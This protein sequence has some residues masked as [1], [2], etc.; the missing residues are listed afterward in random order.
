M[1]KFFGETYLYRDLYNVFIGIFEM[2]FGYKTYSLFLSTIK[3]IMYVG[4]SLFIP[5]VLQP[6][7]SPDLRPCGL[8]QNWKKSSKDVI[9]GLKR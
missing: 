8:F 5:V 6:P 9:L 3:N 4:S 7:Y 1:L 2:C